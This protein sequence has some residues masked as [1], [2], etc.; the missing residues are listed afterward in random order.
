MKRI[1]DD[2][3]SRTLIDLELRTAGKAL[4]HRR[5]SLM[6]P[7]E[8]LK[9][10][11]AACPAL[12]ASD[13]TSSENRGGRQAIPLLPAEKAGLI[14]DGAYVFGTWPLRALSFGVRHSLSFL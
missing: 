14:S 6:A 10:Y 11:F 2:E 5:A 13:L 9:A 7:R 3:K 4:S 1:Q 8:S 12:S